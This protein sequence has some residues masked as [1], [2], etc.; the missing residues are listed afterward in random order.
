MMAE[1]GAFLEPKITESKA[2]DEPLCVGR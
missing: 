2:L 1:T